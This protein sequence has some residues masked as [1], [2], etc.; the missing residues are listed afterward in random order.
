V[1]LAGNPPALVPE[2]RQAAEWRLLLA[3]GAARARGPLTRP[4]RALHLVRTAH[5]QAADTVPSPRLDPPFP[6][7]VPPSAGTAAP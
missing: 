4:G 6:R 1:L 7:L 2:A 5:H 3:P